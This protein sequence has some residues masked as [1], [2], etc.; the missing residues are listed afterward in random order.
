MGASSLR[1][2]LAEH[3][4]TVDKVARHLRTLNPPIIYDHGGRL[5]IITPLPIQK[6]T[7]HRWAARPLDRLS[8]RFG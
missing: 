5:A 4:R 3:A 2:S 8:L 6:S 1:Y 7:R